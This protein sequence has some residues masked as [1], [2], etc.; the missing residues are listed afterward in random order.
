MRHKFLR[1][2]LIL[3]VL[4]LLL[5]SAAPG[6]D[7]NVMFAAAVD[8]NPVGA[9][10]QFTLSLILS[11]AGTSGGTNLRPPELSAFR[12]ISGPNRS[13]NMQIINGQMS[14]SITY[15][16]VLQP[17]KTGSFMIG[18]A[19]IE[20]GG[21][22]RATKPLKLDVVKGQPQR[23]QPAQTGDVA[24]LIGDNL[25]L[26]ATVDKTRVTQGEQI[27]LTFK[28]Y[29]R[30]SVLNYSVEKV[31]SMRGFW[32]EDVETP[33]NISLSTEVVKGKQYRVGVIKRLALFPTQGGTLEI[34]AMEVQTTVQ[35]QPRKSTDPF[36]SFFRDPFGRN[37]NHT[38]KSNPVKIRVSP[39]P[40][41]APD[42][43]KGA[44][45]QFAMSAAVDRRTTR[46]NEPVTLKITISGTGNIKL[47]ESPEIEVPPDFERYSPKVT[48]SINRGKG[49]ISGSKGFEHLLI[50]RYPG[51]KVIK[52]LTFCYYD[53]GRREYVT[54][55]SPQ[56]ELNVEQGAMATPQV[57][58]GARADVQLLTQDIRFIK[59]SDPSLGRSG[60]FLHTGG[61]FLVLLFLPLAGFA[62]AFVFARQRQAEM[63]DQPGYRNRRAI[64]VAQKGL[65]QAEYLLKERSGSKGEPSSLQRVRFYSEISRAL[66]KYLGDKLGISQSELSLERASEALKDHSVD[67]GL[68]HALR[69]LLESCDMARFAPTGLD[70]VAMQK[71]YGEAR[72]I[73]IDLEKTL[74]SS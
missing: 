47:L 65:K 54:L 57:G 15:S 36:E 22:T 20:V 32:S 46:T 68:I 17:K 19:T 9:G 1:R 6:Q 49:K 41:G 3:A 25:F 8:K 74:R 16:Y 29:T 45:G 56:I 30:V 23:Q 13:T 48:D 67:Q 26:K 52:P 33:K 42:E 11:N 21:K 62:G 24:S 71:T 72:R 10:D 35:V 66:W 61:L 14:S 37:V 50:P 40:G 18:A 12:I 2:G 73:I 43:F 59:V 4:P 39:L 51:L 64:K 34:S 70:L 55:R 28:L 44:V 38:V 27:N 60:E 58:G 7:Q 5:S 31:P 69:V 63:R 53:L